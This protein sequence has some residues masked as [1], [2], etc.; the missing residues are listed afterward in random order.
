MGL[1]A[2][3]SLEFLI[4]FAAL[5]VFLAVLLPI[6]SAAQEKAREKIID[7]T[8]KLAFQQL[9]DLTRKA[10]VL[11]VESMVSSKVRFTANASLEFEEPTSILRMVYSNSGAKEINETL[12]FPA[13]VE[14]TEFEEGHYVVQAKFEQNAVQLTLIHE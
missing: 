3:A 8:Q 5:A 6:Y 4:V 10:E 1:K 7:E 9:V 11:G 12:G 13:K 14:T 2:Q